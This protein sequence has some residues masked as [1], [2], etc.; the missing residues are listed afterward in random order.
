VLLLLETSAL[1]K[2]C[3]KG[4]PILE[5]RFQATFGLIWEVKN[6]GWPEVAALWL[7]TC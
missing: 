7:A 5:G 1:Q 4:H 3:V 6:G 2:G